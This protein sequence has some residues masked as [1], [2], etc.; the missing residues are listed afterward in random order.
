MCGSTSRSIFIRYQ[1]L[2]NTIPP[3]EQPSFPHR[4]L[5]SRLALW[6]L[7]VKLSNLAL[8]LHLQTSSVP[9]APFF[10]SVFVYYSL[11]LVPPLQVF[12]S[13]RMFVS[14]AQLTAQIQVSR[15]LGKHT[16]LTHKIQIPFDKIPFYRARSRES[17]VKPL[18]PLAPDQQIADFI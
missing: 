17:D 12:N 4:S 7:Q 13:R 5:F 9:T 1:K 14:S 3:P 6:T 2:Y 10:P 11:D 18:S 15:F 16:R 8:S